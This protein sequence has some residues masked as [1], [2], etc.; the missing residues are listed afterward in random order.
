LGSYSCWVYS[1]L[2]SPFDWLHKRDVYITCFT[3]L[4]L[5]HEWEYDIFLRQ[6]TANEMR[7]NGSV[8]AAIVFLMFFAFF[9]SVL[10][11]LN[12]LF[13]DVGICSIC[14]VALGFSSLTTKV[15][16]KGEA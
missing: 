16:K 7:Y 11:M 8:I 1:I 9:A 10:L 4:Q 6:L 5:R 14:S 12:F 2:F 3:V 15:P 13:V